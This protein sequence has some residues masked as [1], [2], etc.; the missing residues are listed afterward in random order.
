MHR[1]RPPGRSG[2]RGRV[3]LRH[4]PPARR[5]RRSSS[6]SSRYGRCSSSDSV[7]RPAQSVACPRRSRAAS[8][9]I[10]ATTA[11]LVR[12][13]SC[14][15]WTNAS[16]AVSSR[17]AGSRSA[18]PTVPPRGVASRRRG[19]RGYRG[20]HRVGDL[21]SVHGHADAAEDR[22]AERPAELGAGLRDPGR[23]AGALGR[24]GA[25]D[26]VGAQRAHRAEA[27][28]HAHG[29]R[30]QREDGARQVKRLGFGTGTGAAPAARARAAAMT[31][32]PI[33]KPT[34]TRRTRGALHPLAGLP[35]HRPTG[36]PPTRR[37]Q[38]CAAAG[39]ET[40]PG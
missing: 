40:S 19:L 16:A 25:D 1:D 8:T 38:P 11:A 4:H 7:G 9:A 29:A 15:P 33:R 5:R 35:P 39:R 3:G 22:D 21:A 26:Q 30:H 2:R 12:A 31:D 28:P 24:C 34:P 17:P 37:W 13:A 14:S 27:H 10:P 6:R 18:A 36:L 32:T 20:G 23:R